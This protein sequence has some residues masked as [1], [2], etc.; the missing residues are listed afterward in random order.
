MILEEMY[1][2]KFYPCENVVAD[3]PAYKQALKACADLMDTLAERLNKEDFKLVEE[4]RAQQSIAQ[5]EENESHFKY[6]FSAGLL[7][8]QEAYEQILL[9]LKE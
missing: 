6:G 3:S 1:D 9:H 7:V 8:Q 4:L 2:G 5:C